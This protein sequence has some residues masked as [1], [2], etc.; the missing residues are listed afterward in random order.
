MARI[1][2]LTK[3][4]KNYPDESRFLKVK[5]SHQSHFIGRLQ[6][7]FLGLPFHLFPRHF[8][9]W[10]NDTIKSMGVHSVTHIDAPWHY[11]PKVNGVKAKT[12]DEIPL[13][14]CYGDGVI[15]DMTHK[16][17]MEI[18]SKEDIQKAVR[19][20]GITIK[21]GTIVLIRTGRDA[22]MGKKEYMTSGTGM[23]A[24][25][26]EWLID[27][28]VKVMGIDQWGWDLPLSKQAKRIRKKSSSPE[29]YWEGHRVGCRK[30]YCHLEQVVGL[31]QLPYDGFKV[32]AMPLPLQRCSASPVRLI[33]IIEE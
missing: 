23:S 18:I 20:T 17:D 10:A 9:G 13:E 19:E 6:I 22:L 27:L 11:G 7:A 14:W 8:I 2:D 1:I 15:I 29:T 30:E 24:E 12:V 5:I 21:A 32:I 16:K 28:G 26:T 25:A 33:A 4:I 3:P 31:N